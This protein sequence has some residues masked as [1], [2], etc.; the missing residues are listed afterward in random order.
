ME[1]NSLATDNFSPLKSGRASLRI[2]GI[3]AILGSLCCVGPYLLAALGISSSIALYLITLFEW[4]RPFFISLAF[5]AL[6]FSYQQIWRPEAAYNL[7]QAC[8]K[9]QTI[10]VYKA[11]FLFI[12]VLVVAVL[13]LPY[14][15]SGTK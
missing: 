5:I 13:M 14:I 7:R 6:C 11:Y 4:P 8:V 9:P 12:L 2:G 10:N 3:A 1:L 15:V